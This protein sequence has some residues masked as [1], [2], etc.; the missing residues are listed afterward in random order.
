M[1]LLLDTNVFLWCIADDSRLSSSSK[2]LFSNEDS[3]LFLSL[4]SLWEIFIKVG[5]GKLTFTCDYPERFLR[6]QLEQNAISILGIT[7]EHVAGLLRLPSLHKDPFDRLIISQ[8][9]HEELPV[10][11]SDSIFSDYGVQNFF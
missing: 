10:L 7:I 5:I 8:A 9:L 11:S 4:A 6:D 3:R 2:A 1:R